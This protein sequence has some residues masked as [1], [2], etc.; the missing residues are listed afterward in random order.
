MQAHP[1]MGLGWAVQYMRFLCISWN[2]FLSL[3]FAQYLPEHNRNGSYL[4]STL[5]PPN[6]HKTTTYY[7]L[8][9]KYL[10]CFLTIAVL[11]CN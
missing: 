11:H 8:M 1:S 6:Q 4:N 10:F 3:L 7:W 9:V 2:I 5:N